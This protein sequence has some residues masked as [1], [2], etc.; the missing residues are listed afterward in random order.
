MN[1]LLLLDFGS[2]FTNNIEKVL[3]DNNIGFITKK[4]DCDISILDDGIKGIIISGSK[5]AVY[6]NGRRCD[7]LFFRSNR[8]VLGICYGHQ[9]INDDF[10]GTVKKASVPEID[11]KIVF[12]V[13]KDNPIFN[14]MN[15]EQNV[16]MFHGDEVVKIGD[17]FECLGHTNDC[18]YAATYNKDYNITTLQ[19]H[20]EC[21]KYTEFT[22]LYFINFAKICGIKQ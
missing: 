17:G 12:N 21:R 6:D 8:P 20:P 18:K 15:K 22:D 3:F 1:K 11:K 16:A 4:H 19:F 7:G 2:T 14:G 10:N 13:E 5:D 9:L